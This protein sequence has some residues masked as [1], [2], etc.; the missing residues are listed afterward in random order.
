MLD[1]ARFGLRIGY[2]DGTVIEA[3]GNN[4]WPSEYG[5]RTK[6]LFQYLDGLLEPKAQ[7]KKGA[8]SL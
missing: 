4:A 6:A 1:G 2:A 7:W 3:S 8:G 5:K